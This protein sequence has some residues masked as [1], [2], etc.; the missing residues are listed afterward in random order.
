MREL[1]LGQMPCSPSCS[2]FMDASKDFDT[3]NL[4]HLFDKLLNRGV[5]VYIVR[6][7]V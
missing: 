7:L 4:W 2:S 3:V 1:C 5:P 6:M